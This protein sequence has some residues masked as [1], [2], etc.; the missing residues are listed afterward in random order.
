MASNPV[1]HARTKHIEIDIHFVRDRV[2][3][4]LLDVRFVDS[5]HQ[6]ADMLTKPLSIPHF[7]GF[8]NKLLLREPPHH[9]RGVL[10]QLAQLLRSMVS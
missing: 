2:L 3:A 9:L 5:S 7:T 1:F 8:L 6:T 10:E 4:K